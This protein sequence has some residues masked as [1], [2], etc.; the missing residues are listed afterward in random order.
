MDGSWKIGQVASEAGVSVDAV[1]FYERRG[2][3]PEPRRGESGYRQYTSATVERIRF[4][5]ALQAIGFSLDDVVA[6][7]RDV[8]AG[9]ATCQNEQPRFETVLARI[10]EKIAELTAVRRR[11]RQTL[12]RCREGRCTFSEKKSAASESR[13]RKAS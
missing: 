2:V 4:A 8:D 5:K 7:L 1:R 10:D 6:V 9:T 13:A 11:L 3:L 12:T